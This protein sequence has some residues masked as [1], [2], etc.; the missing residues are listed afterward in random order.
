[1]DAPIQRLRQPISHGPFL[2]FL[3]DREAVAELQ[4]ATDRGNIPK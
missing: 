3:R 4:E 1:M 2:S